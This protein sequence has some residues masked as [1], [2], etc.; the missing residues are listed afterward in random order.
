M[1][2]GTATMFH[3]LRPDE[4]VLLKYLKDNG[5]F[6]WWGG[7][8]DLVPRQNGFAEYCDLK[9]EAQRPL[10]PN[11]HRADEWRGDPRRRQL[12]FLLRGPARY[13]R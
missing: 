9:Y 1:C 7:K 13:R 5:Y 6:V 4:P 8:N 11:L 2:A 12:L 3:M 10:Q